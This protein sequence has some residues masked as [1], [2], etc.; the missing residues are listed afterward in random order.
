M[1]HSAL[2]ATSAN[3]RKTWPDARPRLAIIM[4]SGWREVAH[5]FPPGATMDFN[6]IPLLGRPGVEGHGGQI[7]L[8]EYAGTEVLI[9]AG[10]RHWYEG[11]GLEAIAFPVHLAKTLGAGGLLLTNSAGGLNPS[12]PP[13]SI[14]I[15]E[16]HINGMGMNPLA[17]THDPFWGPRF[18]DMSQV[19]DAG[20]R[21]LLRQ[22]AAGTGLHLVQGTYMAV[23]GPSYET[24]A[25]IAA[26]RTMGADAVGMSTVPEAILAHAAG[27]RVAGLSCITNMAA[28]L[29][30]A[31]SHQDV[32]AQAHA[33]LPGL[34]RLLQTFVQALSQ[35][36]NTG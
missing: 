28:V 22:C 26:F 23:S 19:Y 4:G 35:S 9:F 1:N 25:E 15:L 18:P 6:A 14:M 16:D 2:S 33:A 10:R 8:T 30:G 34:T 7:L 32:L 5:G 13:G 17:G 11:A 12:Y 36:P 31:L 29:S 3:I 20:Y 27:L 24:P 21:T